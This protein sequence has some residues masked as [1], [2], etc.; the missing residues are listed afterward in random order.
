MATTN[1]AYF[2]GTNDGLQEVAPHGQSDSKLWTFSLWFNKDALGTFTDFLS[3]NPGNRAVRAGT[4]STNL[5][6]VQANLPDSSTLALDIR[7]S[8]SAF[9]AGVWNH[10]ACS[11]D[12]ADTAKRHLYLNGVSSLATVTKYTDSVLDFTNP[13]TVGVQGTGSR[14]M[15]GSLAEIWIDFENYMDLSDSAVLEKF[16][17]SDGKAAYLGANGELPTGSQPEV[18]LGNP[19]SSFEL[20]L[21]AGSDYSVTGALADATG[22]EAGPLPETAN[23]SCERDVEHALFHRD[24]EF[25]PNRFH[26]F[27]AV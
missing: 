11:V 27:D 22:P 5:I 25:P 1:A 23:W 15:K 18:Y 19:Y 3:G 17:T 9:S 10:L 2:D 20:N 4:I 14:R 12:M 7:T 24:I 26:R 13:M 21:A 16:R 8:T 6:I